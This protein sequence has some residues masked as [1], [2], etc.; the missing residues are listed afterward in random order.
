MN[1]IVNSTGNETDFSEKDDP[2]SFLNKIKSNKTT[3]EEAKA[4]QNDFS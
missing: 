3:L 1:F 2:I 4:S